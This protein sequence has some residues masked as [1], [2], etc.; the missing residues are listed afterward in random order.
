METL[1]NGGRVVNM[2]SLAGIAGTSAAASASH[3]GATK[4]ALNGITQTMA[5][6]Y[7]PAKIRYISRFLLCSVKQTN[8]LESTQFVQQLSKQ[9]WSENSCKWLRIRPKAWFG[10][11][12]DEIECIK[13]FK[14]IT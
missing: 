1:G 5:L 8:I 4:H 7:I 3:Y 2:S 9:T 12:F 13:I 11:F 6:E 14:N 10:I